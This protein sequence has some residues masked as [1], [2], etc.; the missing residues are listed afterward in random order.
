M[1][2][3]TWAAAGVGLAI[4]IGLPIVA[5]W[6]RGVREN[7]CAFDG[8]RVETLFRVEAVD[9]TG[10]RHEFCCIRCAQLWWSRQR[11]YP[12]A[13]FVTDEEDGQLMDAMSAYFVRSSVVTTPTT[14]NRIHSFRSKGSAEKHAQ[15]AKGTVLDG[16][17]RP[18]HSVRLMP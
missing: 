4:L 15:S 9:A 5:R 13:I 18:F 17:E 6:T 12:Q 2:K 14:G 3:G 1:R 16:F 11:E 8:V 7:R 10:Q